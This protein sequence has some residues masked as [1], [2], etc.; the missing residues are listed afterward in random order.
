MTFEVDWALKTNYLFYFIYIAVQ[1]GFHCIF[2]VF[3]HLCSVL[4]TAVY[5]DVHHGFHCISNRFFPV[6]PV[7]P[8]NV[9]FPLLLSSSRCCPCAVQLI[10]T[11]HQPLPVCFSFN[12][13]YNSTKFWYVFSTEK[14]KIVNELFFPWTWHF[15]IVLCNFFRHLKH[16]WMKVGYVLK[17]DIHHFVHELVIFD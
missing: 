5:I 16:N 11:E 8:P 6:V 3:P 9:S 2:S 17:R 7:F 1:H 13:N 15:S 4:Y 10:A 14:N 12:R